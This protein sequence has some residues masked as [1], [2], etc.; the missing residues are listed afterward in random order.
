MPKQTQFPL[1]ALQL[2]SSSLK[3]CFHATAIVTVDLQLT[4]T[5][6]GDGVVKTRLKYQ[7]LHYTL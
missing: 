1:K 7:K 6:C 5:D 4:A 3:A 2:L